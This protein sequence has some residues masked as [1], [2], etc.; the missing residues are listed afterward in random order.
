MRAGN[1]FVVDSN[2]IAKLYLRDK[3]EQWVAKADKLFD[4]FGQGRVE[5]IAPR[6]IIYEVP[7]A[8]RRAVQIRRLSELD[9]LEAVKRF[10]QLPLPLVEETTNLLEEAFRLANRY[11]CT[12]YD[13]IYLKLAEDLGWDFVTADEKSIIRPLGDKLSYIVPLR[14]LN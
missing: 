2:V 6:L 14:S 10:Q 1:C 4:Q 9:A 5:L 8:I 7:A 12:F 11:Y 3:Y 13:A